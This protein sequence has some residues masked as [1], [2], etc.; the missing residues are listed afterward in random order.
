MTREKIK[1]S[2]A[3]G[4]AT[5][6]RRDL[7]VETL[8]FLV[9]QARSPDDVIICPAR[10]ED[11][12]RQAFFEI[13]PKGKFVKGGMGSAFQRNTILDSTSA[14]IVVFFDDDFLPAADYLTEVERLFLSNE[15]IVVATGGVLAD[16][17]SGPGLSF[18]EGTSI[19]DSAGDNN[20]GAPHETYGGYGCNMIIRM[21]VVRKHQVRFDENLPLYAW[22]EDIDFS[23]QLAPYG[24]IV[25]SPRL[26][27]V[28][29]GTKRAGR[30]PGRQ[31]GYS[32][33]ANPIYMARKGT[34]S[35]RYASKLVSN[36][37]ISNLLR[38]F[39]PEPWIDRRG[40]LVGNL[41]AIKDYFTAK[42]D[43]RKIL[44]M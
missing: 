21:D 28:H 26:R 27:G 14:D 9:N 25:N 12:D 16:G 44:E 5:A 24:R 17:I 6:G 34:M 30:S 40:R 13:F 29:L 33:V 18:A 32:Q 22:Q 2:I 43:P 20:G 37:L 7:I 23:R 10:E 38:S 36:N 8:K 19:L 42:L 11:T 15:D 4:I 39:A 31:L 41:S 3:I 35:W 1:P